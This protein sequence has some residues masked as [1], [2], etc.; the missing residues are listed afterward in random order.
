MTRSAQRLSSDK[1][2][3]CV[4]VCC[5]G[6]Q[7]KEHCVAF[8]KN[9]TATPARGDFSHGAGQAIRVQS[10]PQVVKPK[11]APGLLQNGTVQRQPMG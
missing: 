2:C 4:C 11:E 7:G 6:T 5:G 9:R 1:G 10:I 8:K 3:V